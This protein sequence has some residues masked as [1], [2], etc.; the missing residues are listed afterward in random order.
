LLIVMVATHAPVTFNVFL[1][2]LPII[3]L[4]FFALGVGLIMSSIAPFFRDSVHLYTVLLTL[5]MYLTPIFYPFEILPEPV[6]PF[7]IFNP[8][9]SIVE[10]VRIITLHGA[11]PPFILNITCLTPGIVFCMIG[12]WVFYCMQDQF[13]LHV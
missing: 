8:L 7:I 11:A 1:L 13:I 9:T 6:K 3:Y 12:L 4:F 10:Y 5:W 2:I